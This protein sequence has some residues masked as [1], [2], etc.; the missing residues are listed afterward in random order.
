MSGRVLNSNSDYWPW[1]LPSV[2]KGRGASYTKTL[3]MIFNGIHRYIPILVKSDNN[4]IWHEFLITFVQLV[5]VTG[6]ELSLK[7]GLWQKKQLTIK[8]LAFYKQST[9]GNRISRSF[10]DKCR[11]H[12]ISPFTTESTRNKISRLLRGKYKVRCCNFYEMNKAV[13][14]EMNI[15]RASYRKW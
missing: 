15:K 3:L 5:L 14:R 9:T 2:R 7:Y 4:R 13:G 12:D 10:R 8:H 6:T 1:K 11:K